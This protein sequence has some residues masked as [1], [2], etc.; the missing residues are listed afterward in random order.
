MIRHLTLNVIYCIIASA[1]VGQAHWG[2]AALIWFVW[3][4]MLIGHVSNIKRT[5]ENYRIE[6]EVHRSAMDWTREQE[7]QRRTK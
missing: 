2:W 5:Y 4:L 6:E 3:L 1:I 7:R